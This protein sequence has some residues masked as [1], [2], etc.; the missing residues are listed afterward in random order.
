MVNQNVYK[1]DY[2]HGRSF[3][4]VKFF[5]VVVTIAW[6]GLCFLSLWATEP[7]IAPDIE[8]MDTNP[9]IKTI[10]NCYYQDGKPYCIVEINDSWDF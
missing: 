4:W 9:T 3:D 7:V 2:S 1:N 5:L 6:M 10:E 8:P